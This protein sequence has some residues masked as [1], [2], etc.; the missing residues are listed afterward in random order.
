MVVGEGAEPQVPPSAAVSASMQVRQAT[1]TNG[2]W[3]TRGIDQASARCNEYGNKTRS[4][5]K[6]PMRA[7]CVSESSLV[8]FR[9]QTVTKPMGTFGITKEARNRLA[10]LKM[11]SSGRRSTLF[12]VRNVELVLIEFPILVRLFNYGTLAMLGFGGSRDSI[13]RMPKPEPVR[14]LIEQY[15]PISPRVHFS[16][17]NVRLS[18]S[19][20]HPCP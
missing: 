12:L 18:Q 3:E 2:G 15:Q 11:A 8:L 5:I 10:V 14:E 13:K 16:S 9:G 19:A 6:S 1:T 7:G 4:G 17:G 20:H